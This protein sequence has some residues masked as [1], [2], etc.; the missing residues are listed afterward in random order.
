VTQLRASFK[1]SSG[2]IESGRAIL[3]K[4]FAQDSRRSLSRAPD[5]LAFSRIS[6]RSPLPMTDAEVAQLAATLPRLR[7]VG[8]N[9]A[10]D[11]AVETGPQSASAAARIDAEIEQALSAALTR[12]HKLTMQGGH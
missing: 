7:P 6:G 5:Y 2:I 3:A 10:S 4:V 11:R 8:V 9:G 1:T 12:L